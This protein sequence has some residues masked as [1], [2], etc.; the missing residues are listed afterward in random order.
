MTGEI[1]R[2]ALY[3]RNPYCR[4]ENDCCPEEADDGGWVK[5]EDHLAVEIGGRPVRAASFFCRNA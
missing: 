3:Y 5:Y 4:A 2:H 1:T